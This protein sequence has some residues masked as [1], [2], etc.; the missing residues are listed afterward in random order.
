MNKLDRDII[1]MIVLLF[2]S[3]ITLC[4]IVWYCL[5]FP[6]MIFNA[7]IYD[8]FGDYL[9]IAGIIGICLWI[10][11]LYAFNG[12]LKSYLKGDNNVG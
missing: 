10:F 8:F 6:G 3:I 4:S 9:W 7:W 12:L 1:A 2:L 11:L 5:T